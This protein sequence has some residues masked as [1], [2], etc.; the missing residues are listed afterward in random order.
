VRDSIR[1][2]A[3]RRAPAALAVTSHEEATLKI[4]P[5]LLAQVSEG[6]VVL[7]LGAGATLGAT[8]GKDAAPPDAT[9][10][11]DVIT[12]KFLPKAYAD[13]TLAWV[14]E[15]ASSATDLFTVQDFIATQFDDL[16]PAPFHLL[17]PTFVWRG[18]ATTNY[19]RLIEIVYDTVG[20]PVQ[21]VV[22]F[23]SNDDRVDQ[24]L[25]DN[26]NVALLKLH[27]CVTRT[28][29]SDLPLILSLDQ[30][31]S[32]RSKRTRLFG[33][34]EEWASENTIVFVGHRLQ[35]PHLRAILLDIIRE[36]PS[37]P[38]YYLIR[39]SVDSVERDFWASKNVTVLDGSFQDFVTALDKTMDT[40]TRRLVA[41]VTADHPI[42]RRFV[43]NDPPSQALLDLLEHDW[44]YVHEGLPVE[45]GDAKQFYR[46][47]GQQWFPIIRGLDVRRGL[48]DQ[49]LSDVIVRPEEDRPSLVE[50]YAIR[51]EAGAG[52]T[53][54]LR[55]I[56]WEAATR[57]G[58][59]CLFL[60]NPA[61]QAFETLRELSV[62]TGERLFLFIDN[63]AHRNW[64]IRDLAAWSVQ[65][66]LRITLV[67]AERLN[68]WNT[69]CDMLE[70]Y[71]SDA[72]QLRYLS[73]N[74]IE[75]LVQLLGDHDS[76]GPN[77]EPKT[78]AERADEFEKKAG[79]QLLVALH[80]ATLGQPFQEILMDEFDSI[81]PKEAK[82]LYL[83]VC[84]LNRLKVPVRAGLISRIHGI[85]FEEFQKR[86]FKPLEHVVHVSQLPWGD[87]AYRARHSEIAQMVF[88][89]A[90]ADTAD[91][92]NEYSR[93]LRA[94]N[95]IYSVDLSALRDMIRAK[96]IHRMFPNYEDARAIYELVAEVLPEDAYVFQ[97]R[98][99]Y[100]RIRPDGNLKLA[101]ALLS[102]ARDLEPRDTSILH[103]LAEVLRARAEAA[104]PMLERARYRGEAA[105]ALRAIG[106]NSPADRYAVVTRLKLA[107]DDV[108]DLLGE[109]DSSDRELD[110]AIR[111]VERTL[112][113]ARQRYPGDQFVLSCEADFA[114]LLRDHERSIRALEAARK[115]NP[116]D[117]FIAS[118]LAAILIERGDSQ[119]AREYL[120]V[121]LDSNHGDKRLNFQYAEMLRL[122][123]STREPELAYFY[124]RSFTKWDQ[125]YESQFWYARFAYE[126]AEQSDVA[127]AREVFRHLRNVPLSHDDRVK[128]RDVVGGSGSPTDF[129]GAVTRVDGTHGFLLMD[130]RG[131]SLFFHESDVNE[132][133]WE[134]LRSGVRV[135]F[136]KAFSL[137]GPKAVRVRLDRPAVDRLPLG[138]GSSGA[139]MG[140]KADRFPKDCLVP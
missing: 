88:D 102:K 3:R 57:A 84:T 66:K 6:R 12:A 62:A 55:R 42:R 29:D 126:S 80:E 87:Y 15:L 39:P 119:R 113:G 101:E 90:L 125:N 18:L 34:W 38:R 9:R 92:F 105:A 78:P 133:V 1:T 138:G 40:R 52:K 73:R 45:N 33:M 122:G 35:D 99:N 98:A 74:E 70:D 93:I 17:L 117:P 44:E 51:A 24:K 81:T 103:T 79:R 23:L 37:R 60:R 86:L 140:V 25:R 5:A 82:S 28:H 49:V 69:S 72:F 106:A 131:D 120:E 118:R 7:F 65:R 46:G 116:R 76:L 130:G 53:V 58:A 111:G 20:D 22:P 31:A 110:E 41:H 123:R 61:P 134:R 63:A 108:R 128:V 67:T 68:E 109:Q 75:V 26:T 14:A 71:L 16:R 95:P 91:R 11:R 115:A 124:R 21:R 89:G 139:A 13:Q 36:F 59:L 2:V 132:G 50:L 104:G 135:V 107:T 8:I 129:R 47:L 96:A 94:L 85:P 54:L 32:Y 127:E 4:P 121:A 10:L 64:F 114:T 56:A 19:D 83:T 48:T 27:G 137:R 100:E 77:L 136:A 30:Y 43:T 112:D 97:Q